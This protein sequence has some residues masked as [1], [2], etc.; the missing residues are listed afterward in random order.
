MRTYTAML[1]PENYPNKKKTMR[2]NKGQFAQGNAGRP[3]GSKNV[4]S[5][6]IRTSIENLLVNSFE[7]IEEDLAQLTPNERIKAYLKLIE[8][9]VPKQRQ[10][11]EKLDLSSMSEQEIN[12]LIQWPTKYLGSLFAISSYPDWNPAINV[13]YWPTADDPKRTFAYQEKV[14]IKNPTPP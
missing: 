7:T 8:F 10:V 2:N 6:D 9:I 4:A 11:Q 14:L 1:A 5:K 12:R 13:R 3:K